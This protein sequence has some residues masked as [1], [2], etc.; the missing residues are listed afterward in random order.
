MQTAVDWYCY[1]TTADSRIRKEIVHHRCVACVL[2]TDTFDFLA[3]QK[4]VGNAYILG[5]TPAG[6]FGAHH[7]YLGRI[8]FGIYYLLTLGGFGIGWIVDW[9]RM[10]W[11]VERANNVDRQLLGTR[12]VYTT[13]IINFVLRVYAQ[14]NLVFG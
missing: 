6:L 10:P 3:I 11:L 7:F 4:T 5:A 2:F 12:L 1:Y 13:K 14:L 8:T 9:I